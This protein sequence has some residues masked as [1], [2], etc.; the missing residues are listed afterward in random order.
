MPIYDIF[1]NIVGYTESVEPSWPLPVP[2]DNF[3]DIPYPVIDSTEVQPVTVRG[4]IAMH[5]NTIRPW[6]AQNFL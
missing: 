1:G 3:G 5:T 4:L 2:Q 6:L